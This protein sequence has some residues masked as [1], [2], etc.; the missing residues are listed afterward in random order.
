MRLRRLLWLVAVVAPGSGCSSAAT[1]TDDGSARHSETAGQLAASSTHVVRG[2]VTDVEKGAAVDYQDGSGAVITPR[3]LVLDVDE[4][5]F[6]RDLAS[7]TPA[8]LTVQD[9]Y[10]EDGHL[11]GQEHVDWA[12]PGD[13]AVL[14]LSRDR[15]SR[16]R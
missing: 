12:R 7:E 13:T 5:L 3:V 9:G 10:W 4:Y 6:T 2:R 11:H 8:T 1:D 16:T 14:F 15:P